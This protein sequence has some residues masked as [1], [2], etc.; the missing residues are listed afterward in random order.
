MIWLIRLV[1][2]VIAVLCIILAFVPGRRGK[3]DH[4]AAAQG[5]V[6]G[7]RTQKIYRHGNEILAFAPVVRYQT[8]GGEITSASRNYVPEW[9]YNYHLGDAVDITYNT[10]QP[11]LFVMNP[12]THLRKCILLTIGIGTLIA[13]AALWVQDYLN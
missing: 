5:E 9:Q 10:Q 13:G 4:P 11:D 12:D 7:T 2:A 1:P 6:V 3:I 8:P